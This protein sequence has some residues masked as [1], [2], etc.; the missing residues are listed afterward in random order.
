[1]KTAQFKC[2]DPRIPTRWVYGN[3]TIKDDNSAS[4]HIPNPKMYSAATKYQVKAFITAAV[5]L[6]DLENNPLFSNIREDNKGLIEILRKETESLRL[7]YIAKT[8]EYAKRMFEAAEKIVVMPL[9][10]LYQH[11]KVKYEMLPDYS[12]KLVLT[13]LK[14][15]YRSGNVNKLRKSLWAAQDLVKT[16]YEKFEA[17]EVRFAEIHYESSLHKLSDRIET[18][19]LNQSKLTVL[20]SHIGV[21]INTTLTDGIQTVRAFTIIAEG[22]IKRPHYRYLI[23]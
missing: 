19:G 22:P 7:Q 5:A 16:G 17:K 13:P 1:M 10:M 14:E 8:T 2:P 20:T 23:K 9:E 3:I 12:G 15:E 11:Y 4:V 6:G 18:K 21:N